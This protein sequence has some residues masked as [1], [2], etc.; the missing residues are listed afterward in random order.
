M[1]LLCFLYWQRWHEWIFLVLRKK[2]AQNRCTLSHQGLARYWVQSSFVSFDL[3]TCLIFENL[4]MNSCLVFL[5]FRNIT[6]LKPRSHKHIPKP[7]D[8]VVMPKKVCIL[9]LASDIKCQ[10]IHPIDGASWLACVLY[11]EPNSCIND[12][13]QMV[14]ICKF[15]SSTI[16]FFKEKF[17]Y[18]VFPF[19]STV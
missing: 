7:P 13:A 11:L 17:Y 4:Q 8:G 3:Y 9:I 2:C 12:M 14:T 6:Y 10:W 1:Y 18:L 5:N 19:G 15:V 16:I